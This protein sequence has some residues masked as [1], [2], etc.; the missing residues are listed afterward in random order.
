MKGIRMRGGEDE[1]RK[2]K[3]V[4]IKEGRARLKRDK[5][6]KSFFFNF[7][8]WYLKEMMVIWPTLS[9]C[10]TLPLFVVTVKVTN[11]LGSLST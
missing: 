8:M 6:I 4:I 7:F 10:H 11:Y 3:I 1:G 2:M 9:I 5:I